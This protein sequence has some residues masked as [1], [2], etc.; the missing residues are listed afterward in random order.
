MR[1]S[2]L[3]SANAFMRLGAAALDRGWKSDPEYADRMVQRYLSFKAGS[4]PVREKLPCQLDYQAL[5]TLAAMSGEF[6]AGSPEEIAAAIGRFFG[7]RPRHLEVA[8]A[9]YAAGVTG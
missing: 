4:D 7:E 3:I 8:G 2:F 6:A 5:A 1:V 9:E